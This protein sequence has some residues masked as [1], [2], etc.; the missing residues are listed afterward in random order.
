MQYAVDFQNVDVVNDILNDTTR[1]VM[2]SERGID[3]AFQCAIATGNAVLVKLF[4]IPICRASEFIVEQTFK[5]YSSLG[6]CI[7]I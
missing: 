3:S 7:V 2:L 4:L 1:G 5:R 6:T